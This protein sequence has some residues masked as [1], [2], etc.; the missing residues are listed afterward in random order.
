MSGVVGDG[1]RFHQGRG[2]M[3]SSQGLVDTQL[4]G[5]CIGLEVFWA[6]ASD[7]AMA[8]GPIVKAFNVV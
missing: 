1:K 3:W 2:A 5:L 4:G 8:S 6:D 7:M